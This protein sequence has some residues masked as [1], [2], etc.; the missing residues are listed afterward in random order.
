[1]SKWINPRSTATH[2]NVV[3]QRSASQP[4]QAGKRYR[5]GLDKLAI[6]SPHMPEG[7]VIALSRGTRFLGNYKWCVW[8]E[9]LRRVDV[10]IHDSRI[11]RVTITDEPDESAPQP[12]R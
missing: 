7:E 5:I 11:T 6:L 10:E 8:T 3:R 12:L 4:F 1:M 9:N 2:S